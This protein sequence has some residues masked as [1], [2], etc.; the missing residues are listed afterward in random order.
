MY[1]PVYLTSTLLIVSITLSLP[2]PIKLQR[3]DRSGIEPTYT[4]KET[5]NDVR[6]VL[7]Y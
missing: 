5:R 1:I 3:S 2:V 7:N 6:I 4:H